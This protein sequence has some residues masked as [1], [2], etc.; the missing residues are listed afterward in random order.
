MGWPMAIILS[1]W[2]G[3]PPL[4]NTELSLSWPSSYPLHMRLNNTIILAILL[5]MR[6]S[7][8]LLSW[9][10][11]SPEAGLTLSWPSS[12][13]EDGLTLSW[14]SSSPEAGLYNY[15]GHPPLL[16][17]DYT[18]ILAILLSMRLSYTIILAI[19]LS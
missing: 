11:S 8:I 14:P 10:S 13:P 1:L 9:P 18:I 5:S 17:L 16:R 15:P 6:P 7:Y 4:L 3:H 19:L 12:S 2:L